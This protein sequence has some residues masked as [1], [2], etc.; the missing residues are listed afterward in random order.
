MVVVK[1]YYCLKTLLPKKH[2][3][4]HTRTIDMMERIQK[5][6][7]RFSVDFPKRVTLAMI[8]VMVV[9]MILVGL[10]TFMPTTFPALHPITIDT[11]PENMLSPEEPVR[12]HHDRMK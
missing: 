5:A 7:I 9:P 10:G 3:P 2:R 12:I 4:D 6:M 8:M 1:K 11:D